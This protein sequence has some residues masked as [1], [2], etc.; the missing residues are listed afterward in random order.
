MPETRVGSGVLPR[1]ISDITHR[2]TEIEVGGPCGKLDP[3]HQQGKKNVN[4]C[5]LTPFTEPQKIA[6]P[7]RNLLSRPPHRKRSDRGR[8]SGS[9]GVWYDAVA[10]SQ[11]KDFGKDTA[12]SGNFD[13]HSSPISSAVTG[14]RPAQLPCVRKCQDACCAAGRTSALLL[15]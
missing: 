3:K 15:D 1:A 10:Q 6:P 7:R 9:E 13:I 5:T 14:P 11:V 12:A 2:H 8:A 4:P